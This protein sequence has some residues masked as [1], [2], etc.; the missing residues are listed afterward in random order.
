[1]AEQLKK[2]RVEVT[3]ELVSLRYVSLCKRFLLGGG[4]SVEAG[5]VT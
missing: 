3:H 5:E 1:M 4:G 2:N